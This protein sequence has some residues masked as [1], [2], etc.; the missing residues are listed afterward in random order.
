MFHEVTKEK[1]NQM[2]VLLN[3]AG[4]V[5]KRL[6]FKAIPDK[7]RIPEGA[8]LSW[9]YY[10][11]IK[12]ISNPSGWLLPTVAYF[13]MGDAIAEVSF[14]D[15]PAPGNKL[16]RSF[17][18]TVQATESTKDFN[19]LRDKV[20]EEIHSQKVWNATNY[21]TNKKKLREKIMELFSC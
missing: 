18:I 21:I 2:F 15:K 9:R 16:T 8:M 1:G 14:F 17:K 4:Q 10:V 7:Y 13:Y 12:D 5:F 3:R 19:N 6:Q 20:L 11:E